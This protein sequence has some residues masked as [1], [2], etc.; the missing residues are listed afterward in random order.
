MRITCIILFLFVGLTNSFSISLNPDSTHIKQNISFDEQNI[1]KQPLPYPLQNIYMSGY[2][3]LQVYSRYMTEAYDEHNSNPRT[4]SIGDGYRLPTLE[5]NFGGNPTSNTWFGS[6]LYFIPKYKGPNYTGENTFALGLGV[7]LSGGIKTNFGKI[8]IEGGGLNWKKVSPLTLWQNEGL[9]RFSI[10]DRSPWEITG[11]ATTRY[12]EFYS[13]GSI[14][15]DVRWGRRAFSGIHFSMTDM[16]GKFSTQFMYGKT[17][18][19]GG[20][21]SYLSDYIP[22]QIYLAQ[23]KK[24][25]NDK[26]FIG[27]N[28][29]DNIVKTDSVN[30]EN[31]GYSI[32]TVEFNIKLNQIVLS[33]EIG[34]GTYYSPNYDNDTW[35]EGILLNI[36]TS[37]TL[38]K[39]PIHLQ[40]YR[41]GKY[42]INP[43]GTFYNTSIAEAQQS[44]FNLSNSQSIR[45]FD[46]PV[47]SI[48]Q[49]TNNRQG[50]NINTELKL[51]NY[52]LSLGYGIATELEKISPSIS[53]NH[54][55]NGLMFSRLSLFQ[56]QIGPY[57]RIQSGWMGYFEKIGITD[58]DTDSV[59]LYRKNF[60]FV[61]IHSKLKLKLF[62]RNLYI[63]HLAVLNSVQNSF[64][65]YP[66]LS[67]KAYLHIISNEFDLYYSITKKL[68]LTSYLGIEQAKGNDKT[69]LNT[70]NRNLAENPATYLPIDQT[71]IGIG[72]GFDIDITENTGLHFRHRWFTYSDK[73]YA[74]DK[75]SGNETTI[76]LKVIF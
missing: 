25:F 66:E 51:K 70:Y 58:L 48:G 49:V 6:Q 44:A 61:E 26:Q 33:G 68:T 1:S 13:R 27:L 50:F 73:N 5:L 31:Y 9:N 18:Y 54:R 53:Y 57:N 24:H 42:F 35:S 22:N 59:P 15:Q 76:E 74:D 67:S 38:T 62:G 39:L 46:S 32:K 10:F 60:N 20:V 47:T 45:P 8:N 11:N 52:H 36:N 43:N 75:Y 64:S 29:I 30:A 16:P 19:N 28:S 17:E 65:I 69:E 37:K 34:A 21:N 72:I 4:I 12:D 71:G 41:L 14:Q 7:N 56:S 63:F 55:V 3:R 40:L 23:V 2:Y